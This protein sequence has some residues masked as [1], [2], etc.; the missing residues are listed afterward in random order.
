MTLQPLRNVEGTALSNSV[1]LR[2]WGV[3]ARDGSAL[4]IVAE[5]IVDVE[6]ASP[7]YLHIVPVDHYEGSP[8]ECWVCVPYRHVAIDA[9]ERRVVM[10]DIALLGLGTASMELAAVRLR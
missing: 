10:S 5:V 3:I 4:G 8:T 6:A 7:V 9:G 2:G 1:D